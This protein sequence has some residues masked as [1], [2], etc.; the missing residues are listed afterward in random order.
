[1][2]MRQRIARFGAGKV[3]AAGLVLTGLAAGVGLAGLDVS[4]FWLSLILLGLGW[5]FGFV[6]SSAM[7]LETHRP[8]EGARVQALND[9]VVFGI[10]AVGSFS[11]GALLTAFGWQVVLWVSLLPLALAVLALALALRPG[12]RA[13]A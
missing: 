3:V 13:P 7:V 1:M 12:R 11:S 9:F 5:N 8:E 2:R 4:H 10:M 6:G